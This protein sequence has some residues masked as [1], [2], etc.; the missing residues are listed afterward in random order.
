MALLIDRFVL[1]AAGAM[2]ER[3]HNQWMPSQEARILRDEADGMT[4]WSEADGRLFFGKKGQPWV[5]LKPEMQGDGH[6]VSVDVDGKVEVSLDGTS[7]T[8]TWT[9]DEIGVELVMDAEWLDATN[10]LRGQV[11]A[12]NLDDNAKWARLIL[13]FT[14]TKGF[15]P[16]TDQIAFQKRW[17]Y[18]MRPVE[19]P[20]H[21]LGIETRADFGTW[22]FGWGSRVGMVSDDLTGQLRSEDAATTDLYLPII[23]GYNDYGGVSVFINPR[24][25]WGFSWSTT[26]QVLTRRFYL[27]P[28]KG[29]EESGLDDGAGDGE[30]PYE[31]FVH[32]TDSPDWGDL[33]N[34][35]YLPQFPFLTQPANVPVPAGA[36]ASFWNWADADWESYFD[37]FTHRAGIRFIHGFS[38][39]ATKGFGVETRDMPPKLAPIVREK[40]VSPFLWTN[41]RMAPNVD[42]DRRYSDPDYQ[43][44]NFKD[45]LTLNQRG[46][47]YQSWSGYSVNHSPEFSFGKYQLE[48]LL[49]EVD[50]FDLDGIFMDYYDD[51]VQID[52]GKTYKHY[53]FYPLN[54]ATIKFTRA[55]TEELHARGKYFINNCPNPAL[56]VHQFSDAY[57]ADPPHQDAALWYRLQLP[58]K[59]YIHL[60]NPAHRTF[61]SRERV[62]EINSAVWHQ[63][64]LSRAHYG[65]IPALW[66]TRRGSNHGLETATDPD[67]LLDLFSRNIAF[68]EFMADGHILGGGD[69]FVKLHHDLRNGVYGLSYRNNTDAMMRVDFYVPERFELQGNYGVLEW[70]LTDG[71]RLLAENKSLKELQSLEAKRFLTPHD[72]RFFI[73][74]PSDKVQELTSRLQV[75]PSGN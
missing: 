61:N 64:V 59:P 58:Y 62:E 40:G 33:Y 53:P 8:G 43:W 41:I 4:I 44:T 21:E 73:L 1:D 6:G 27:A 71:P 13:P 48:R 38:T 30:I 34:H 69:P 55:L 57:A 63:V 24:N 22:I 26:R 35:T 9:F 66:S 54:V 15:G 19:F 65:A 70:S 25:A 51:T 28:E 56:V 52:W 36:M 49:R 67:K 45:A 75:V 74:I 12:I 37:D 7:F 39:F 72:A 47:F 16:A 32:L 17:I 68:W 29:F 2:F 3:P 46:E 42:M 60:P 10:S 23:C 50:E 5:T 11:R 31:F 20:L 14:Y 18:E